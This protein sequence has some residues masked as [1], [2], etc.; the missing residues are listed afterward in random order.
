MVKKEKEFK[1]VFEY[2]WVLLWFPS[3][4]GVFWLPS[5]FWTIWNADSKVII[6]AETPPQPCQNFSSRRQFPL[7]DTAAYSKAAPPK[8]ASFPLSKARTSKFLYILEKPL[9]AK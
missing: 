8:S 3:L 4:P 1:A 2:D 7:T 9:H 6:W 5:P